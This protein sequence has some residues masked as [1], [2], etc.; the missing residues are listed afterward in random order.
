MLAGGNT[1]FSR[2]V[3]LVHLFGLRTLR[4]STATGAVPAHATGGA[5]V[6]PAMVTPAPVT[7]DD[8]LRKRL[9]TVFGSPADP[10]EDI[11]LRAEQLL[12]DLDAIVWE[13]D[14][15][16]FHFSYV[17]PSAD[18]VLGYSRVRWT[19]DATF[20]T[21]TVIHPEDRDDAVS[22]CALATARGED[23]DF[24]Y[25]AIRADGR[26]RRLYDAVRLV[27]GPRGFATHIRGIMIDLGDDAPAA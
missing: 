13:G 25:R 15:A 21:H 8:T 20:W 24:E 4:M 17:S 2:R 18:R 9:D 5:S 16:T 23:H 11:A 3:P 12:P 10:I 27:K 22:F 6:S 19:Q 7:I 1:G 14:A 26:V